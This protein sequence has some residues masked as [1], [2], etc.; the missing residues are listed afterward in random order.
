MTL[1][2]NNFHAKLY[3]D[4]FR[5]LRLEGSE[6]PKNKDTSPLATLLQI[7]VSCSSV[8]RHTASAVN[9]SLNV[10]KLLRIRNTRLRL[11]HLTVVLQRIPTW[12]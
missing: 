9:N 6:F 7:F 3:F 11:H 8:Y 5:S 2:W 1:A 12:K 10:T 4:L